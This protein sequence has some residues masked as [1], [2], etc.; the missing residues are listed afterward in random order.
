MKNN[1]VALFDFCETLVK[2]QSA[3]RY[4]DYVRNNN[5]NFIIQIRHYV[6]M[7]LKVSRIIKILQYI[8]P[9][10][11]INK[12]LTLWQIKGLSYN[13]MT[14]MGKR[15]YEELIKPNLIP[16]VINRLIN[17]QNNG[18]R[19]VLV[20]G[21]YDIYLYYFAHEFNIK[22]EDI[23]SNR[24]EFINNVFTGHML[25]PDCLRDEKVRRLEQKFHKEMYQFIAFSDSITDLPMLLWADEAYIIRN[26]NNN[27]WNNNYNFNEVIWE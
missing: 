27:N 13:I 12:R 18:A 10:I 17:L 5:S 21:A 15:Y 3:D 25:G 22:E 24:F 1:I 11:N 23:I 26:R 4:V 19:I 2:F 14:K 20:S 6:Y 16:E 9:K 8:Y 7:F